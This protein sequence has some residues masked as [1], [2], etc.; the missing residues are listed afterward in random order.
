MTMRQQQDDATIVRSIVDLAANL[1]LSVV[2]EGV[3]DAATCED[4]AA[5]GCDLI[6][7]YFLARPMPLRDFEVWLTEHAGRLVTSG[8]T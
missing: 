8:L 5:M 3:E 2:A 4:L 7:G 1:G 6:Q